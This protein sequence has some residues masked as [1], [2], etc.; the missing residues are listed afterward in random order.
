MRLEDGMLLVMGGALQAC[1]RHG[2]PRDPR[3][4]APRINLTFRTIM[5][6]AGERS[7]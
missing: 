6:E 3:C 4:D 7:P 1:Y 5:G 2:V